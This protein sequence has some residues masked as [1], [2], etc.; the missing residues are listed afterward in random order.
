MGASAS[1]LHCGRNK[2]KEKSTRVN[3]DKLGKKNR[4][5]ST[6]LRELVKDLHSFWKSSDL[7]TRSE[8]DNLESFNLAQILKLIHHITIREYS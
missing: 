8:L 7:P 6:S 5:H 2:S 1:R 3:P 4:R